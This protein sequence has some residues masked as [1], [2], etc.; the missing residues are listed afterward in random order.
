MARPR[1]GPTFV[2][3]S[4]A[5]SPEQK[6]LY[7]HVLGAGKARVK[8]EFFDLSSADLDAIAQRLDAAMTRQL[9]QEQ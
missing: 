6:A 2:Q 8:R 7:H 1:R 4:R 5:V 3:A 9:R